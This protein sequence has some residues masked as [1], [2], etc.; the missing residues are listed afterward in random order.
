MIVV[1]TPQDCMR[2]SSEPGY[3]E[4]IYPLFFITSSIISGNWNTMPDIYGFFHVMM[5]SSSN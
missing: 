3:F 2:F 4:A 1:P 5:N